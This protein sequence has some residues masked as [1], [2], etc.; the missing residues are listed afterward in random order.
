[1]SAAEAPSRATQDIDVPLSRSLRP[2]GPVK[3][4]L[5]EE[6]EHQRTLLRL[7]GELDLLTA[8][9]LAARLDEAVRQREGDV[10]VDLSEVEFVDSAGLHALLNGQR[11]LIRLSRRLSVI[12]GPGPVRRVFELARLVETLGVVSA[13]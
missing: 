11:R 9:K 7:S 4:G 10:V 12:C 8:P 6:I 5:L 2:R 3:L 1:M 13:T